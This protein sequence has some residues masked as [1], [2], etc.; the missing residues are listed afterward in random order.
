MRPVNPPA[1]LDKE[2]EGGGEGGGEG[3]DTNQQ[4]LAVF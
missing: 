2:R 1:A 3:G 4:G